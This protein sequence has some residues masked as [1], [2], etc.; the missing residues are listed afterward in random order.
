[1]FR[2]AA[3]LMAVFVGLNGNAA[4]SDALPEVM[5]LNEIAKAKA[6]IFL[7]NKSQYF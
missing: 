6:R 4:N 3:V 2:L 7:A 1:M 5:L